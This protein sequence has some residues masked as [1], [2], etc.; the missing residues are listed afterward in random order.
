MG[1]WGAVPRCKRGVRRG[2]ASQPV[3]EAWRGV[4]CREMGGALGLH[5]DRN[6]AGSRE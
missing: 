2:G 5:K 4:G 1:G 6:E 3:E